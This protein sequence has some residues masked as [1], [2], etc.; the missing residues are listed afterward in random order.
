MN[1]LSNHGIEINSWYVSRL[2]IYMSMYP[3]ETKL[4]SN[5][6]KYPFLFQLDK[7][8]ASRQFLFLLVK[9]KKK[10]PLILLAQ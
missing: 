6:E 3:I 7:Q 8:L 5:D 10:Y 2:K 1:S 9:L 4:K